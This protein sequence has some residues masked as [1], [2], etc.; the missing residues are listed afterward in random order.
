MKRIRLYGMTAVILSFSVIMTGCGFVD[1]PDLTDEQ[2]NAISEYA[3]ELLLKYGVDGNSRLM[4]ESEIKQAEQEKI[5]NEKAHAN[6]LAGINSTNEPETENAESKSADGETITDTTISSFYGI[7][8][9]DIEFNDFDVC[10]SYPGDLSNKGTDGSDSESSGEN[11]T[12][13]KSDKSEKTAEQTT[14]DEESESTVSAG[15]LAPS[16]NSSVVDSVYFS[17]DADPGKK[18]VVLNFTASNKTDSDID[19]DMTSYSPALSVSLDGG[20][21][22]PVLT[23]FVPNDMATYSGKVPAGGSV[24]MTC[25]VQTSEDKASSISSIVLNMKNKDSNASIKLQ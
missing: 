2:N 18:L 24:D 16:D 11:K 4:S 20:S 21:K 3:V 19:L 12:D 23:T 8:G 1:I 15:K 14:T 10:S 9:I 13:T 22:L 5:E 6:E 25:M 7:E 17:L